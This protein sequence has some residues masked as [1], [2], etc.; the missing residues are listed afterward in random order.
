MLVFIFKYFICTFRSLHTGSYAL[1]LWKDNRSA[2]Y[3]Y[4]ALSSDC[5][6]C[7]F[8]SL[9][10][11]VVWQQGVWKN[12]SLQIPSLR[13]DCKSFSL[14]EKWGQ[15]K[16]KGRWR[17]AVWSTAVA[18]PQLDKANPRP[19]SKSLSFHTQAKNGGPSSLLIW[20]RLPLRS[21]VAFTDGIIQMKRVKMEEKVASN[22]PKKTKNVKK[23][24]KGKIFT[25]DWVIQVGNT[26]E[27]AKKAESPF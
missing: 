26:N 11:S 13:V 1:L 12:Q 22:T 14:S 23:R 5:P 17:A 21:A 10:N 7:P 6:H 15:T 24:G 20:R 4:P 25:W 9:N 8:V 16:A 27:R 18:V 2:L 19:G 3:K